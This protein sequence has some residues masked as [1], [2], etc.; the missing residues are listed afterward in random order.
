[1][2]HIPAHQYL[3]NLSK[4]FFLLES[5][6]D[7]QFF[8][9]LGNNKDHYKGSGDLLG[10]EN[11]TGSSPS[12]FVLGCPMS[13]V[14]P[15]LAAVWQL[16]NYEH[17]TI[18]KFG[19]TYDIKGLT[20]ALPKGQFQITTSI[21]H[22]M[23]VNQMGSGGLCRIVVDGVHLFPRIAMYSKQDWM[24]QVKDW[25][26]YCT[27]Q[28]FDHYL[29]MLVMAG[30][31]KDPIEQARSG[32]HWSGL[33]LN[34]IAPNYLPDDVH[35]DEEWHKRRDKYRDE[36]IDCIWEGRAEID[37][38]KGGPAFSEVMA[39]IKSFYHHL[40]QVGMLYHQNDA[41]WGHNLDR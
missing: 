20:T 18:D 8:T 36:F 17:S 38:A 35:D 26:V 33:V 40:W 11:G 14:G 32:R 1:M 6:A 37:Q 31:N 34:A 13:D 25:P 30:T 22:T 39:R 28:M 7:H 24:Y 27:P 12:R 3:L 2:L 10:L 9:V 41:S 4:D 29:Q 5:F 19:E 23:P 21:D 16:S 15:M